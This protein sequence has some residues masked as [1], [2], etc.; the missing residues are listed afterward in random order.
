[1]ND[2]VRLVNDMVRFEKGTV[3]F[4]NSTKC[5]LHRTVRFTCVFARFRVF[6]TSTYT[7]TFELF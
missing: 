6:T 1:M 4:G 2:G 5:F 3:R 7:L